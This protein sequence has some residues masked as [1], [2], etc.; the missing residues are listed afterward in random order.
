MATLVMGDDLL[1]SLCEVVG[2]NKDQCR[3]IILDINVRQVVTAYVEV[4]ADAA[5]EDL[6]WDIGL[7]KVEPK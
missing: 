2:V 7:T 5:I 1:N 6:K 4:F 3:R